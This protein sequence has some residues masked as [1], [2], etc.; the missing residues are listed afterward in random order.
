M[1]W[2]NIVKIIVSE[3]ICRITSPELAF[4][5]NRLKI[6]PANKHIPT[7]HGNPIN[8]DVNKENDVFCVIVFLSFLALAADIAG[9]KAVANATLIDNGKLVNISTFPPNIP[10]WEI[11]ISSD[12]NSFKL[13]T[14][15]NESIFLFKEDIIAVKAIGMET[16]RILFIIVRTLSYL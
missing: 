12:I 10:Y 14:T 13:L 2:S 5:N 3:L 15:V 8:I 1:V 6:G 7:V 9:T 16:I 4:G 11:A